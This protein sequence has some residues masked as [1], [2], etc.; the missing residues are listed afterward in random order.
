MTQNKKQHSIYSTYTRPAAENNEVHELGQTFND[1]AE[2]INNQLSQLQSND[3]QR[4]ELLTHL[5]HDLRTP[6]ASLQGY[7]ETVE[8]K[9]PELTAEQQEKFIG[10]AFK[11]AS[12]L[13]Q[14][15]E[16]IFELANLEDGNVSV[17]PETFPL[18]ELLHDIVA[19]FAI[20]ALEKNIKL[21]VEPEHLD[22][23]IHSDIGK[24][25]RVISNL[26]ENA[27]RHCG[28]DGKIIV[29]VT[30]DDNQQLIIKVIDNGT[31]INREDLPF[32]FDAGFRASNAIEDI[33]QHS[34]LGLAI[35]QK[36]MQLLQSEIS[37]TSQ[38]GDGTTFSLKLIRS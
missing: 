37:V 8:L 18:G 24:L 19:K 22:I 30:E 11:N 4:R 31:G 5:S 29:N 23:T 28:S 34:G 35:C 16:Q 10:I 12:H 6:L 9:G 20:K 3:K 21:M 25:E 38:V 33:N 32:L 26:I 15:V 1:M 13:K 2:Q 36:L 7:L 27:I 14:L 17:N